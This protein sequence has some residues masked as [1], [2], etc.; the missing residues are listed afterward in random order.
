M[1]LL[2]DRKANDE[3]NVSGLRPDR[4]WVSWAQFA[5]YIEKKK[6]INTR[7]TRLYAGVAVGRGRDEREQT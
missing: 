1:I 4:R 2:R 6:K 7:I 5:G 3:R